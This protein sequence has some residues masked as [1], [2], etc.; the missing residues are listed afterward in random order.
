MSSISNSG[1]KHPDMT[2]NPKK[3]PAKYLIRLLYLFCLSL[4]L[5]LGG[6]QVS[7][8]LEKN[9]IEARAEQQNQ[10]IVINRQQNWYDI[11]YKM[12]T[13][14]GHWLQGKT[15]LLDNRIHQGKLGYEV[16][17]PIRLSS[18]DSVLLVN[19]GWLEKSRIRADID[20]D[21]E[22]GIEQVVAVDNGV[23]QPEKVMGQLSVPEK[24]FTLGAA[25]TNVSSWPK[26]I[27]YFD[28]AALS[29]ALQ[30]ELQ[31]AVVVMESN[32]G[33]G[34]SKIWSP[35]VINATRHFGYAVQWWGLA[36]VLMV[37][38]FIWHPNK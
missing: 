35:Y 24:G 10:H 9:Q 22:L 34:L 17:Q 19:M 31:A 18:D 13:L 29:S 33:R 6:W 26:I 23:A 20:W 12:V 4:L 21:V 7:R 32:P 15:F 37:F 16:L 1:Q 27:Q 30:L 2:T 11:K 8:G 38:G 36:L 5:G 3:K 25:Y 28:Q 14:E